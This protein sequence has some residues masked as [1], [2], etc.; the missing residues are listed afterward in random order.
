MI[1]LRDRVGVLNG[2]VPAQSN[3]RSI[4]RLY[5]LYRYNLIQ[6]AGDDGLQRQ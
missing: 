1:M 6:R 3:V 4:D 5:S 2:R